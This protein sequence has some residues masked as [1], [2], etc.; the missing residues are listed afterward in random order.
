MYVYIIYDVELNAK[1]Q[2]VN[3]RQFFRQFYYFYPVS[4]SFLPLWKAYFTALETAG[5]AKRQG[6]GPGPQG[7]GPQGPQGAQAD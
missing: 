4:C 3:I 7:Q 6:K 5:T 2:V 1:F